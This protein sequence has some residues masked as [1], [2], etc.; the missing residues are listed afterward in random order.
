[1]KSL[2]IL[3]LFGVGLASSRVEGAAEFDHTH[4]TYGIVLQRSVTN[5][6]VDYAALKAQP[7]QLNAYLDQLAGV[8]ENEFKSW[9]RE[10]QLAFLINLYN[11]ATLRLI[12]DHYPISSIKKIGHVFKGPWDQPVVRLFGKTTTLDHVEHGILRKQYPDPR[13]HFALVCAA[14]GCPPLREEPYIGERLDRQLTDQGKAF[15]RNSD[16]NSVDLKNQVIY[17]SPIF[18]WFEAD[19]TQKAPSVRA[20]VAPFFRPE[21]SRALQKGIWKIKFTEYDWSLNA[22]SPAQR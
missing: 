18:K 16:K 7:A 1:M 3:F 11:A 20:F 19:F 21:D 22:V 12:I 10:N 4:A 14:R 13:I 6:L 15:L 17:L 2:L 9:T 8:R 5:A